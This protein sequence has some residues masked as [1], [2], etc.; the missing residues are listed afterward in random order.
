ML[1][2]TAPPDRARYTVTGSRTLELHLRSSHCLPFPKR[3]MK[4]ALIFKARS[5]GMGG[6]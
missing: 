2:A 4:P 6:E 3:S 5:S 1:H